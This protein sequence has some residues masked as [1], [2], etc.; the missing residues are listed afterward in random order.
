MLRVESAPSIDV[1]QQRLAALLGPRFTV[2]LTLSGDGS[3]VSHYHLEIEHNGS[4]LTLEDSGS[5]NPG[6]A[7]R[8][9]ALTGHLKAMLETQTFEKMLSDAPDRP[10]V[11]I[12]DRM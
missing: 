9:L 6:Y 12:R 2:T 1:V 5:L 7:E 10:L 3:V 11:W 8:L 4:G